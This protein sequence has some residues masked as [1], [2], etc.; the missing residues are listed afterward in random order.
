MGYFDDDDDKSIRSTKAFVEDDRKNLITSKAFAE[1]EN[2]SLIGTEAIDEKDNK[3][4]NKKVGNTTIKFEENDGVENN[5][6]KNLCEYEDNLRIEYSRENDEK[7]NRMKLRQ[8]DN[9]NALGDKT[10][11]F[12]TGNSNLQQ[13]Y[14]QEAILKIYSEFT[15]DDSD[16]SVNSKTCIEND[17]D[18]KRNT[19]EIIRDSFMRHQIMN[20]EESMSEFIS[21]LRR[22]KRSLKM[23]QVFK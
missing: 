18:Q 6:Y 13:Q 8:V 3:K 12:D 11:G 16:N 23:R 1:D 15:E 17:D 10:T 22:V 9:G 14:K 21:D 2:K 20:E 4:E 5:I 7:D 19:S